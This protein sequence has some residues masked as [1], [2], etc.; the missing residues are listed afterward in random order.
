M[1][2]RRIALWS[3][4]LLCLTFQPVH[5]ADTRTIAFTGSDENFP[6]PE[7]GFFPSQWHAFGSGT[8]RRPLNVR[9]LSAYRA[10]GI[11]LVNVIYNIDEF[12]DTE[13]SQSGWRADPSTRSRA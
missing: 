8:A 9:D 2:A 4:V 10:Q 7:R 11:T 6:N 3:A 1:M 5:S 13:L 12:R